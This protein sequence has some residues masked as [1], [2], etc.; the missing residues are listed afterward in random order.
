MVGPVDKQFSTFMEHE[1]P[2]SW[3]QEPDMGPYPEP[4]TSSSHPHTLIKTYFKAV[5]PLRRRDC[6]SIKKKSLYN[7][8]LVETSVHNGASPTSATTMQW[9]L[10]MN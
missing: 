8:L 9:R 5:L 2:I 1:G 3:S 6:D 7:S 4:D 10:D